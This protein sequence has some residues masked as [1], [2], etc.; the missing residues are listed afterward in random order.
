MN[1]VFSLLGPIWLDWPF[2]QS[3]LSSADQIGL[4]CQFQSY[5]WSLCNLNSSYAAQNS[6]CK[7]CPIFKNVCQINKCKTRV[8][9]SINQHGLRT[10][11]SQREGDSRFNATTA[12]SINVAQDN[13]KQLRHR[14]SSLFHPR[15]R[16][17]FGMFWISTKAKPWSKN[18]RTVWGGQGF[19]IDQ[20]SVM[21]AIT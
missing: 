14:P 18:R 16:C 3:P 2:S 13:L 6:L 9:K 4:L 15:Q 19:I 21:G 1:G 7:M 5:S 11:W 12:S 20:M 17:K 10:S 8:Y